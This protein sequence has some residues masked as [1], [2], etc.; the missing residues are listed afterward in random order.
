MKKWM[1]LSLLSLSLTVFANGPFVIDHNDIPTFRNNGNS[2]QGLA[3]AKLGTT[4]YEVWHSSIAA[5][6]CT[7]KHSHETE[8]IFIFLKGEGKAIVGGEEVFYQAPCTLVLPPGIEHQ[9]FNTGEVATDHFVILGSG[10][11][12]VNAEGQEMRLPWR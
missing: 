4:Q 11:K 8:E 1:I 9:I 7:P 10:S 3:T 6:S 2:L 12:I 5:G